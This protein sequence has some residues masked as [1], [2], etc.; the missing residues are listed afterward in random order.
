MCCAVQG[1]YRDCLPDVAGW[2][3][4]YSG[5]RDGRYQTVPMGAGAYARAHPPVPVGRGSQADRRHCT[6]IRKFLII[7]EYG[8]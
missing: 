3:C 8:F 2:V 7:N 6:R 4:L 1:V 5:S